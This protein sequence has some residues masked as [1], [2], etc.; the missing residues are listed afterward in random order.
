ML[1]CGSLCQANCVRRCRHCGHVMAPTSSV[2][3]AVTLAMGWR[4]TLLLLACEN[5]FLR[6]VDIARTDRF[7]R[8]KARAIRGIINADPDRFGTLN[9]RRPIETREL[10]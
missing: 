9:D 1:K 7:P 6:H 2:R 4:D 10:A 8:Q 5:R 3:I